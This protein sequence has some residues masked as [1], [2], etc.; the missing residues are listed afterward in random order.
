MLVDNAS[1]VNINKEVSLPIIENIDEDPDAVR[2]SILN[3]NKQDKKKQIE[4]LQK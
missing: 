1:F 4:M 2:E 3:A